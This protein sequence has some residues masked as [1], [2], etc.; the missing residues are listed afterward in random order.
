MKYLLRNYFQKIIRS[1]FFNNSFILGFVLVSGALLF[2]VP[3]N[4]TIN[5]LFVKSFFSKAV[6]DSINSLVFVSSIILILLFYSWAIFNHYKSKTLLSVIIFCLTIYHFYYRFIN[7]NIW[8]YYTIGD[9]FD[10]KSI[11]YF[12][13]IILLAFCHTWLLINNKRWSK[14]VNKKGIINKSLFS[15]DRTYSSTDKLDLLHR[16]N[17]ARK[18]ADEINFFNSDESL[19]IGVIG[20]WGSGKSYF[21][22]MVMSE[23]DLINKEILTIRFNPWRG[24]FNSGILN[25]FFFTLKSSL[26]LYS[27]EI[28][29]QIDNY[30]RQIA[31]ADKSG[32]VDSLK[33]IISQA[34][35]I[36]DEFR[37]IN[38]TLKQIN[39][40]LVIS[41]DDLDRLDKIEICEVLK[42]IRNNANFYN[43]IFISGY[44][45]DY[46][47]NAIREINEYSPQS[48]LEKIFQVEFYL[49]VI[50]NEVI[51]N[52]FK[53]I[54]IEKLGRTEIHITQNINQFFF[55]KDIGAALDQILD[56]EQDY[57]SKKGFTN[58]GVFIQ[59][60]NTLRDVTRLCNSFTFRYSFVQ[61]FVNFE[62]YLLLEVL[63]LKHNNLYGELKLKTFLDSKQHSEGKSSIYLI[64]S[65]LLD[66]YLEKLEYKLNDKDVAIDLI[67][68]IFKIPEPFDKRSI[69]AIQSYDIYFADYLHEKISIIEFSRARETSYENLKAKVDEWIKEA[70]TEDL[71]DFLNN[72][73]EKDFVNKE[74]FEKI[75][76]IFFHLLSRDVRFN[77]DF[78]IHRLEE[79]YI[80]L[81]SRSLYENDQK[82]VE[83]FI[84]DQLT[85]LS[86]ELQQSLIGQLIRGHIYK[87]YPTII[88]I[89]TL[90]DL[91]VINLRKSIQNLEGKKNGISKEDVSMLFII[92]YSCIDN[93][94]EKSSTI[95]LLKKA[96][97]EIRQF[98]NRH[99]HPYLEFLIRPLYTPSDDKT[100]T[101][102]PF[103]QSV[104]VSYDQFERFLN[105]QPTTL[106][107]WELLDF[108]EKF[109]K[110]SYRPIQFEKNR[111]EI[112][113]SNNVRFIEAEE[114]PDLPKNL[115]CI[116]FDHPAYTNITTKIPEFKNAKW[117]AHAFPISNREAKLGGNYNLQYTRILIWENRKIEVASITFFVDDY[118]TLKINGK[119]IFTRQNTFNQVQKT[120]S[121]I[122]ALKDGINQFEFT[123]NNISMDRSDISGMINPYG[124]IFKIVISFK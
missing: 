57:V 101:L 116:E 83:G 48:Y 30:L 2:I 60:I 51:I 118:L 22:E 100:F 114:F 73:K 124:V 98:V 81:I 43:T 40:K 85:A 64:N 41:I 72:I 103:I 62:D 5:Y 68:K 96:S 20:K 15:I 108:F 39:K 110:N 115:G 90:Q 31:F 13:I 66:S 102:E 65:T 3:L 50:R 52:N 42:I 17:A 18:I 105:E 14:A 121:I 74:D 106:V 69:V 97:S 61:G 19:A 16:K 56:I 9:I 38:Q 107:I 45:K 8:D 113:S 35:S 7:L 29:S 120:F 26:S 119:L 44:D 77:I 36:E 33:N 95:N 32:I 89:D 58:E 54:L 49:P 70:K 47:I 75:V 21:L 24:K 82:A 23:I 87:D 28:E 63:K 46:I 12:D 117:I 84:T 6:N 37:I 109:K 80:T 94:E 71:I 123:I 99:P 93:I 78:L 25:H 1:V 53:S 27:G 67:N 11:A 92:Y 4:E 86:I 79:S 111:F 76:K 59:N 112:T 10:I 34:S 88:P 122:S 104:F 91:S 55:S